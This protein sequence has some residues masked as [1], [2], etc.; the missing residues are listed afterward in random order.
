MKGDWRQW[1]AWRRIFSWT[2]VTGIAVMFIGLALLVG[3]IWLIA[4][5]G[6]WYYAIAGLA[7]VVSGC[8][9][10]IRRREGL[11][12]YGI[13]LLGTVI[14][15]LWES[16]LDGWKLM[17]RLF[18]PAIIGIWLCLPWV[19]RPLGGR[20]GHQR[21][22]W[23]GAAA[24]LVLAVAIIALGYRMADLNYKQLSPVADAAAPI[25]VPNPPVADGDWLY[26]GRTADGGRFS[27]LK[28]ITAENVS[29][30][31]KAWE[32]RTGDLPTAVD[33]EKG[34]EFSFEAT[35]IK[36]GDNLYFCTP[37][38]HIF[39]I[40]AATG[41]KN[42]EFD[43][44][45]D[46]SHNIFF[47]CRGVSYYEAPAGKSNVCPRRII[48]T[49]GDGRMFALN[50]DTGA[51]CEDFGNRGFVDLTENIGP[52]PP[53]F[54]FVSS[55]PLIVND[56]V[57]FS[58]WVYDNETEGEPSGV[59]RALDPI[60]GKLIWA[61]D[62]CR[63]DP[64][65][66]LKPGET[67]T[68]GTSNSWATH[69][70]DAA[71]GLVYLPLGNPTPDY[72]GGH[73]RK[74]DDAYNS[75]IVALDIATG[76][77]RWHYQTTH[78]DL[79]DFDLPVGPTLVDLQTPQGMIPALVQTTKRG[80]FF[81]LDRRDGH[82]LTDIV[83]KPAPQ[84][85]APGEYLSPTQPH[86]VFPNLLPDDVTEADAWGATPLDQLWCRV[87][88]RRRR[89]DGL[90]TPPTVGKYLAYPA[91]FGVQDWYGFSLD[92]ARNLLVANSSYL[93]MAMT[94]LPQD[95]AIKK[96]V[97]DPW[98][99]WSDPIPP[100]KSVSDNPQYGTPYSIVITPWWNPLKI[101]CIAPT[102]GKL[103]AI[104]LNTHKIAWQRPLGTTYGSG[105]LGIHLPISLP[106]GIFSM[107]GSMMTAGGVIF[108]GGTADDMFR[109][110]D[111]KTGKELWH[112]HLPAGGNANPMTYMGSDGQ[113]YIVIAAGG[114]GGLRT[115]SGDYVIAY[116]LPKP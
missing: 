102:W 35:P 114:H 18:A 27:P 36:V 66:P 78:H 107:G 1:F 80:E 75:S 40:N 70:A 59:E 95:K 106:T 68:R 16:R 51:L 46:T 6:S 17:P 89:Y 103:T 83:E 22:A 32:F 115:T 77:E 72:F 98:R 42:W 14:W 87:D 86:P 108:I 104:D 47:A 81:V 9:L 101:P 20:E 113:Q 25:P 56:R 54:Y 88:F 105:P 64:N 58:G 63:P 90:F 37:H 53:G 55:Q 38:R 52:S 71:L 34:K 24:C 30:L 7:L 79:W 112:E 69:T 21:N 11:W 61:W 73:R 29:Q 26:Y 2:G 48:S 92:P 85:P 91:F 74:C 13:L 97:T 10:F 33:T 62:M 76:K 3:G 96:G 93:P 94:Y 109:A 8:L 49:S 110:F 50:A 28:Q 41:Q 44:H 116:A 45:G 84:N 5:G 39:S 12:L 60:T 82:P 19:A 15:A 23:W 100:L 43:P 65:A 31:K 99:G 4:L 111:E 67:W 57:I